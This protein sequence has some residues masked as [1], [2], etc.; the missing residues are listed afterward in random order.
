MKNNPLLKKEIKKLLANELISGDINDSDYKEIVKNEDVPYDELMKNPELR[1]KTLEIAQKEYIK[2][3]IDETEYHRIKNLSDMAN[4]PIAI[5][6]NKV[7]FIDIVNYKPK[8]III[9]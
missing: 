9:N 1:N 2:G 4:L 3:N 7:P 6:S 5:N 8:K